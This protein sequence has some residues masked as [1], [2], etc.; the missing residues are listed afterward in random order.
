MDAS[1]HASLDRLKT[2]Q[3]DTLFLHQPSDLLGAHGPALRDALE[4]CRRRGVAMR[5]GVSIYEPMELD[6]LLDVMAI[7]VVQAPLN[8]LDR[9]LINTGALK[10]L[11]NLGIAV[12]V[13]SVFLQGLLLMSSS[14]RNNRFPEWTELWG[15]FDEQLQL[16][17]ASP[18]ET[19]VRFA[20]SVP[21]IEYV[22]VGVSNC[23]ELSEVISAASSTTPLEFPDCH[24]DDVRLIDPRQWVG[25]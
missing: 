20:L 1:V 4:N 25:R 5:I 10:H 6:S 22:V 13:R 7:D 17:D 23:R 9:R 12:H 16:V 2:N 3:I 11:N 21:E 15:A 18:L 8:I 19:C 14:E 24:S